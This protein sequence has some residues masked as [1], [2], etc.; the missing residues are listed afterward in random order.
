MQYL[1]TEIYVQKVDTTKEG[2]KNGAVAI[3]E[4]EL[5]TVGRYKQRGRKKWSG[6]ISEQELPA[7]NRYNQSGRK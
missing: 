7:V 3:S 1:D 4:Q 2:A 5:P 6:S